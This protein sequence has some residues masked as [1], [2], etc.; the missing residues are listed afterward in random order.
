MAKMIAVEGDA[1]EGTDTHNV[2]GPGTGPDGAYTGTGKFKYHGR[3]TDGLST[4]VKIDGKP[5]ALVSSK[6]SLNPGE[7]TAGDHFGPKAVGSAYKKAPDSVSSVPVT[8]TLLISDTGIG[9]GTPNASAGSMLLTI[10]NK[11]VLLDGDAIDTC[12]CN[13]TPK[14]SSVNATGQGFVSCSA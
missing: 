8:L 9:T 5:V 13:D 14:N 3:I 6:S 12:D 10:E 7:D 4:L 2:A 11:R 1:V